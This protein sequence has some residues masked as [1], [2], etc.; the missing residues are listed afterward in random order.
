MSDVVTSLNAGAFQSTCY[1]LWPF[2]LRPQRPRLPRKIYRDGA[3]YRVETRAHSIAV[4]R[5]NVTLLGET[6]FQIPTAIAGFELLL[7]EARGLLRSTRFVIHEAHRRSMCGRR[8]FGCLV[9]RKP[10]PEI[11]RRPN[12]QISIRTH[13]NV[14]VEEHRIRHP[15]EPRPTSQAKL[16]VSQMRGLPASLGE[17]LWAWCAIQGSNL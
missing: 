17:A 10:P 6:L 16:P 4:R 2:L 3:R 9:L 14:R 13:E 15:I 7:P 8:H 1:D 12:V 5:V 11:C